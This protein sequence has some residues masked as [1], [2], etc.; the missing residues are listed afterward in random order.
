MLASAVCAIG[1]RRQDCDAGKCTIVIC[2][3]ASSKWVQQPRST[4]LPQQHRTVVDLAYRRLQMRRGCRRAATRFHSLGLGCATSGSDPYTGNLSCSSSGIMT[5]VSD[6]P[7]STR[8]VSPAHTGNTAGS[9]GGWLVVV[10]DLP[11][12]AVTTRYNIPVMYAAPGLNKKV[13]REDTC[14]ATKSWG[15]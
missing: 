5:A 1:E 2:S 12:N 9:C 3:T 10:V 11:C 8:T 14:T 4:P 7:P 13:T 6:D 15:R